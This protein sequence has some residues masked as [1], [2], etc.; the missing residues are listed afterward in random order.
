MFS[1]VMYRNSEVAPKMAR[2]HKNLE[3]THLSLLV[4]MSIVQIS[5]IHY[6]SGVDPEWVILGANIDSFP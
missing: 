3:R 1:M 6:Y 5:R 4:N 2:H